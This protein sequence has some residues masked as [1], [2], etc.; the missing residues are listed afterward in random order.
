MTLGAIEAMEERGI[1]PGID[2]VIV[3]IDA[4]QAAIDALREGKVN[5]VIER[6]LKTGPEIIELAEKLAP[7]KA[8]RNCNT[9]MKKCSMKPTTF[10]VKAFF[11]GY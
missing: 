6:N 11:C 2:I 3:T 1:R 9:C 7:A 4:Q 5:C 10:L 8:F